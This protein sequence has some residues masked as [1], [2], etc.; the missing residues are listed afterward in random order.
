MKKPVGPPSHT[1]AK[2]IWPDK[3]TSSLGVIL[4]LIHRSD[5]KQFFLFFLQCY[6]NGKQLFILLK[7]KQS[8]TRGLAVVSVL[9][10]SM[11]ARSVESSVL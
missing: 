3:H 4:Y 9:S 7:Y 5:T 8:F 6:H 10:V 1:E 2:H 11:A